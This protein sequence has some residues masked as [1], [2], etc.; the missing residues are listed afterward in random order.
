MIAARPNDV[1]DHRQAVLDV[2]AALAHRARRADDLVDA[3]AFERERGQQRAGL[4]RRKGRVHD[5]A[6]EGRR[7]VGREILS[8]QHA[9]QQWCELSHAESFRQAVR[10]VR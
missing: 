2:E 8:A 10:R 6:D 7:L 9:P 3:L 1:D 5:L 4:D